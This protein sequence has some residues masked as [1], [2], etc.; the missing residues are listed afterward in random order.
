MHSLKSVEQHGT[1]LLFQ[2]IVSN[3]DDIVWPYADH[4]TVKR[5]MV[6]FAEGNTVIHNG[7]TVGFS[8]RDDMSRVQKF[9]MLQAAE[10]ALL[11]ICMQHPLAESC[12]TWPFEA[13]HFP[14]DMDLYLI[15]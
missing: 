10:R 14:D 3:F 15:P 13:R 6:Q 1:I 12:G 11:S 4:E 9:E 2:D 7:I 8:I 5:R